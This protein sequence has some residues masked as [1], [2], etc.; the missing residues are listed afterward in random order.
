MEGSERNTCAGSQAIR[1]R[2]PL[3]WWLSAVLLA[4]VICVAAATRMSPSIAG[5]YHDDGV[6]IVLAKSLAEGTGYTL[7]SLPSPQAQAK[8]PFLYPYVLSLIWRLQPSFPDNIWLLKLLNFVALF[9]ALL[10]TWSLHRH[11]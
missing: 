1:A 11:Y 3:R 7:M 4:G 10:L 5:L 9:A 6:Y 2:R 8:Y